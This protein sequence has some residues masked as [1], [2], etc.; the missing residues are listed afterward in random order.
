MSG[1]K[2]LSQLLQA[3]QPKL[4]PEDYVFCSVSIEQA[5]SLAA[6]PIGQFC[7]S[8]G[9]SLILTRT[10]AEKSG[11]HYE[12]CSRMITLNIHSSLEAV[13]FLAVILGNLA[14]HGISVNPVSAYYH[15]HLFVPIE[16]A[17]Q[18]MHLLSNLS[19]SS[20]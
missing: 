10:D 17:E 1:E 7:E 15:D 13:G 3:M 2:H 4:Q 18:V 11:F 5:T 8:E 9:M 12:Y 14:E 6:T 20:E 19:R 16:K